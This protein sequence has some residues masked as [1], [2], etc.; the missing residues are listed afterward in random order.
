VAYGNLEGKNRRDATIQSGEDMFQSAIR[1]SAK[2]GVIALALVLFWALSAPA[3]QNPPYGTPQ[4]PNVQTP[5]P[6]PGSQFPPYGQTPGQ[7]TQP[8]PPQPQ[9]T[10]PQPTPPQ[11]TPPPPSGARVV[12]GLVVNA[13]GGRLVFQLPH[14]NGAV[15]SINMAPVNVRMNMNFSASAQS[16]QQK[17]Q[18]YLQNMQRMGAQIERN[19]PRTIRGKQFQFVVVRVTNRQNQAQYRVLNLFFPKVGLWLQFICPVSRTNDAISAA[20]VVLKSIKF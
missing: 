13:Y 3:Q 17:M 1:V 4:Q 6:L 14:V 5:Q 20:N 7:P 8:Q 15:Y 10:P 19:Q 2:S 11:P 12:P 9:P 18:T 16:L